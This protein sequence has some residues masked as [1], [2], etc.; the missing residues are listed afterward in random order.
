MEEPLAPLRPAVATALEA[1]LGAHRAVLPAK[2]PAKAPEPPPPPTTI[3]GPRFT[4][5]VAFAIS[6]HSQQTRK[7]STT[8]YLTH[9]LAVAGRVGESGGT[10]DEIIAGLLHDAVED[11]GGAPV[12]EE[13][14]IRFGKDVAAIVAGCTDD[15]SG[16]DKAPWLERKRAYLTGLANANLSTLRVVAADKVH[17]A[18]CLERDLKDHGPSIFHRFRGD[19]E[20]TLWYYRSVARLFGALV[21][22]EPSLDH[23]FRALIRELRETVARLDAG[24]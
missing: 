11:A 12:L 8:P 20:G 18:L 17:N 22:D 9:L 10:E 19:R 4:E 24:A 7:G 14:E 1:V 5:A 23:G 16:A 6:K 21:Q 3:L 13:I 15:D 2:I